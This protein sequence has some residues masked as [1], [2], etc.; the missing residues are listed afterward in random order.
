ME[1]PAANQVTRIEAL[2]DQG[3]TASLGIFSRGPGVKQ[4]I[5]I[6]RVIDG[7]DR[8]DV[9]NLLDKEKVLDKES[10]HLG[11]P[12]QVPGGTMRVDIPWG[13]IRP[14]TDQLPGACKNYLTVGRWVDVSNDQFGVTWTTLD[15][16][17]IEVGGIHMDVPDPFSPASWLQRLEPT[18]TFYSYVMNNYWE[19]NYKASQE[20]MTRFRY[21]IRPHLQYDQAE[22][23]RFA[24]QCSQPLIARPADRDS[25]V[26]TSRLQV[27]GD[28]VL[29][30]SLKPSDDGK[31]LMVRLFNAGSQPTTS[32]ITWPAPAPVQVTLSSPREEVGPPL[33]GP[34]PLPPLG[35]VTVRAE[36]P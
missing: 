35:I 23:T 17:L 11:F 1:T 30:T 32:A 20:G 14:E 5:T 31:A 6:V 9:I 34:V 27:S 12:F 19:T 24:T 7:I 3:L 33:V 25:Q 2:G 16:P 13:V 26:A 28:G 22:A 18:Q 4:L 21:S 36:L 29:V 10:I 8:V 15:A